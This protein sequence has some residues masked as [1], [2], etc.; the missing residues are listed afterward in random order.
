MTKNYTNII[1]LSDKAMVKTQQLPIS[2]QFCPQK[3]R[4]PRKEQVYV[5]N[6]MRFEILILITEFGLSCYQAARVLNLPYTNA[7]VIYRVYREE[8][9]VTSNARYR[10]NTDGMSEGALVANSYIMR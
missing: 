7:K 4:R 10:Q 5:T 8:N 9:R 2:D 1:K 3:I 6:A